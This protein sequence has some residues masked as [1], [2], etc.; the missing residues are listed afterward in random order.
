MKKRLNDIVK[1]DHELQEKV[2]MVRVYHWV[3][4]LVYEHNGV[5]DHED[6]ISFIM[7]YTNNEKRAIDLAEKFEKYWIKNT[8]THCSDCNKLC[9]DEP[10]CVCINDGE[11]QGNCD[12]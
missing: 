6:I 9:V 2:T 12:N 5:L 11:C 10:V 1:P 3:D 8:Y 4:K 7:N